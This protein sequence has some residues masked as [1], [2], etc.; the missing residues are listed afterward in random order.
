MVSYKEIQAS[1]ALINDATAP[2]VAVFAGGTSGIGKFTIRALVSTGA[3]VR[4]YLVGR[5]SSEE[6]SRAFIQELNAINP[7]ADIV[8][9]EGEISLLAE[10]KR[11]CEHIKKT[12]S[13][14]DLLFLTAGYAPFG[15]R[16][17]TSEGVEIAQSLEYY[18]RMLF[19][20]HL[21]PVLSASEAPRVIS[22][23]A[24]GLEKANINVDDL[25]LKDPA[26][27]S[28]IRAQMQYGT[29]NTAFLEKLASQNPN[30][31]FIHSWPGWV[32]TGNMRR[33]WDENSIVA[34]IFWFILEPIVYL[35]GYSDEESGQ[36]YLFQAT[37]AA[38]GGRGIPWG[39]KQGV[40][41]LEKP[42]EGLFLINY[43]CDCT[44]NAKVMP[45]LR[46][47]AQEKVWDHTQQILQPY[48]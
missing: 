31:T 1:N 15:T 14:V 44:P 26:N 6:S 33:G 29:M 21:L 46:E 48:L 34:R 16:K 47:K 30:V 20:L 13:R 11:I 36:R 7:K 23:L 42:E 8:W 4:I 32:S 37:S 40:N 38:F 24:G 39:G 25:D 10:V 18:S 3:S 19:I 2:R 43:S 28:A 22:V 35:F 27:F 9:T 45:L 41:S 17:E 12:E 5:K